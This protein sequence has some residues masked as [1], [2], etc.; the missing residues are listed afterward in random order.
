MAKMKRHCRRQIQSDDEDEETLPQPRVVRTQEPEYHGRRKKIKLIDEDDEEEEVGDKKKSKQVKPSTCEITGDDVE[1][2]HSEDA[3]PIGESIRVSGKNSTKRY[4]FKSFQQEGITFELEDHVLITPDSE[5]ENPGVAIIK[6]IFQTVD[7]SIMINRQWFYHPKQAEKEAGK[8]WKSCDRR[9]LFFS[10]RLEEIPVESVMHKCIVHFIPKHKPIPPRKQHPGFIVHN[11][12]DTKE[13]SI[14]ELTDKHHEESKQHDIDLLVLKSETPG[15]VTSNESE[16]YNI[17]SKFKALTGETKRDKWLEMYLQGI[18][19]ICSPKDNGGVGAENDNRLNN[20]VTFLWPDAAV[21]AVT[22]L[23]KAAHETHSSNFLMYNQKMNQLLVN[24]KNNT[25]LAQRMLNGEL[26]PS[27]I[28]K[29]SSNELKD[30][31]ALLDSISDIDLDG[32]LER[33]DDMAI[34]GVQNTNVDDETQPLSQSDYAG[35]SRRRRG[36]NKNTAVGKLKVGQKMPLKF[37]PIDGK[38]MCDNRTIWSRHI[39]SVIRNPTA[40]PHRTLQW[41][42]LSSTQLDH[43]WRA[44]TDPFRSVGEHIDTYRRQGLYHAK[45]LWGRWR[46]QLNTQYIKAL[47]GDE[48]AI[49][50][51]PPPEIAP[52]DWHYLLDRRF[53][54]PEFKKT[55]TSNSSNRSHVVYKNHAGSVSFT[56]VERQIEK[57]TGQSPNYA[58][59][60]LHTHT[61]KPTLQDSTPEVPAIV[62]EKVSALRTAIEE[63][64][65][66]NE[67]QLTEYAFG[68]QRHGRVLGMGSGVRPTSFRADARGSASSSQRTDIQQLRD[69]NRALQEEMQRMREEREAERQQKMRECSDK[70]P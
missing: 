1:E 28:L 4:H 33:D 32:I 60:F 51:N 61:K 19:F 16:Y 35:S 48:T 21:A 5:F 63:D 23:E 15:S 43:I 52:S 55:S 38:P 27:K 26:E 50:A 3:K 2:E 36:K 64:P 44:I 37:N 25:M 59:L 22:A 58:D 17:L 41:T 67:L 34:D 54:T 11:V 39:G 6:D 69:E 56:Q 10:F 20:A 24:M 31:L 66:R 14:F 68:S 45:Q 47:E 62:S 53:F 18:Q 46:C 9:E 49:R 13:K 12:Y 57:T 65:S 42:D 29:M 7:G 30:P 70:S 40:L 8:S